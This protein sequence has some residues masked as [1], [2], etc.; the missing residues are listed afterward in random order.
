[1]RIRC[2]VK[3]SF[4]NAALEAPHERSCSE[5]DQVVVSDKEGEYLISIGHFEAVKEPKYRRDK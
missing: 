5:G 4:V 1:M 2:L 3:Q